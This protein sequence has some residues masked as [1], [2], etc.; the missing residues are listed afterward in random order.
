MADMTC[1]VCLEPVGSCW[2]MV[3][4]IIYCIPCSPEPK[5]FHVHFLIGN[6]VIYRGAFLNM[7]S[8]ERTRKNLCKEYGQEVDITIMSKH[9]ALRE[10]LDNV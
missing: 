6:E 4:G 2:S 1:A 10:M 5:R 8:V 3:D 9:R 7:R